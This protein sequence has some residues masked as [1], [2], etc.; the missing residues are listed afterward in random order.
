MYNSCISN[1]S[2]V[3]AIAT[4]VSHSIRSHTHRAE[5]S[6]CVGVHVCVCVCVWVCVG[7]WGESQVT[8]KISYIQEMKVVAMVM[9]TV[10]TWPFHPH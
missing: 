9:I 8:G 6:V 7:V 10:H 3:V 4:E 1:H 5:M 2:R